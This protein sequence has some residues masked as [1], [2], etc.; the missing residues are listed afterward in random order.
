MHEAEQ[1]FEGGH[2]RDHIAVDETTGDRLTSRP[3]C[4]LPSAEIDELRHTEVE[5]AST[6][7]LAHAFVPELC[8]KHDGDD[9][10]RTAQRF[11]WPRKP[12]SDSRTARFSSTVRAR[13]GAPARETA[14]TLRS[15]CREN[16]YNVEN[17]VRAE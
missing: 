2:I 4:T 16:R 13:W 11:S 3:G 12:H 8:D 14:P 17:I 7:A 6:N 9:V 5:P 10:L 1:Q 15:E